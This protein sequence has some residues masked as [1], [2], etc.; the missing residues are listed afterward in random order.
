MSA[1]AGVVQFDGAPVDAAAVKKMTTAMALRGPDGCAQRVEG[2]VGLGHCMLRTT[3]ESLH[4]AQPM[5]NEDES[6]VLVMDGRVDNREDLTREL[7]WRGVVLRG[8]TDAEL[9]LRAYETWGEECPHWIVGEFVFFVWDSRRRQLFGARD[10]AGTRH[11]YYHEGAGWFAFA[12]EI[13]GLL[14]LGRIDASLNDSRVVDFIAPEFDRDDE[15]GTFYRNIK[16]LPAGHAIKVAAEGAVSWRYWDPGNLPAASF[17][18]LDECAEAFLEQLRVAVTCRLRSIGPI[19]AALSGGLDSTS[20]VCLI[21][22]EFRGRLSAPLRTFSLIRDDRENCLDWP[23]IRSVIESDDWIDAEI[24]TSSLSGET[25][26]A[27]LAAGCAAD[28]PFALT[29]GLVSHLI[30]GAASAK[31][32]RVALDGMAGDLLFYGYEGSLNAVLRER[33]FGRLPAIFRAHVRHGVGGVSGAGQAARQWLAALAPEYLRNI[34]REARDRRALLRGGAACSYTEATRGALA[35]KYALRREAAAKARNCGDQALHARYFTSGLLS[36]AHEVYG[37]IAFSKGVEPRSPFS[38]RRMIE[39]AVRMP[40]ES[41]LYAEWYKRLL[42]RSMDSILPGEVLW[43][44]S[45]NGNPGWKFH[46]AL[47]QKMVDVYPEICD[48]RRDHLARWVTLDESAESIVDERLLERFGLGAVSVWLN[49]RG[50]SG[51]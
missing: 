16:R 31:G 37:E 19:G 32:C 49:E 6:L 14:A 3:P 30:Y 27:F 22:K 1:I 45:I 20:I 4:E 9:V 29:H 26:R 7:M 43:R 24:L 18:S 5:T 47:F 33:S 35:R 25:C 11:F 50:F 13:K 2:S 40:V 12:S 48:L 39:F 21:S 44:R 8:D 23:C 42:R 10:A 36:F 15:I 46:H 41:K 38:D 17:A 34:Y 28:E 51:G